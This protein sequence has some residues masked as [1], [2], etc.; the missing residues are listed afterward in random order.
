MYVSDNANTN[1]NSYVNCGTT[2]ECV[3]GQCGSNCGVYVTGT[4]G[5]N[6][7]AAEVE[8]FYYS[9]FDSAIIPVSEQRT[10][11]IS[12]GFEDQSLTNVYRASLNGFSATNFHNKVAGYYKT[13]TIIKTTTGY[14]FGYYTNA[15]HSNIDGFASDSGAFMFSY[16]NSQGV[17]LP[18]IKPEMALYNNNRKYGPYFGNDTICPSDFDVNPCS[19]EF[20]AYTAPNGLPAGSAGSTYL[21]NS[22]TFY[23]AEV[24]VFML[25]SIPETQ[26]IDSAS[27]AAFM[28]KMLIENMKLTLI[29]RASDNGFE[30]AAFH[31]KVINIFI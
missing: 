9:D 2:Y 27:Q 15:M 1:A 5:R 29:H 14:V 31:D 7:Q 13:L 18:I 25:A 26:L 12:I 6:Y 10:F 21:I 4:G 24:E 22:T 28:R 30:A 16:I 3:S 20:N 8:V 11:F 17:K 19:L 23:P